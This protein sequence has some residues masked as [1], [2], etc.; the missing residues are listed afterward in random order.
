MEAKI[1]ELEDMEVFFVRHVG[2]YEECKPAWE[3][4]CGW[5]IPK[6]FLRPDSKFLSLC[7]DDPKVTPPEK[8]RLDACVEAPPS[9]SPDAPVSQK[10][11]EG[12]RYAM[13]V[14]HGPYSGL[15]ETYAQLCG[16]WAPQNGCEAESRASIEVYVNNPEETAPEDLITE[17]YVPVK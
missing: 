8:I 1:V 11:V 14:H 7:H 3:A 2:P 9:I 12:G 13:T 6:G 5:A 15:A 10:T 4:L 16:Q 17:I